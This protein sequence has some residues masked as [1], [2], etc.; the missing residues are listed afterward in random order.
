LGIVGAI[1]GGT[2]LGSLRIFC[3]FGL[4]LCGPI[5]GGIGGWI[6]SEIGKELH[7]CKTADSDEQAIKSCLLFLSHGILGGISG[8]GGAF[9]LLYLFLSDV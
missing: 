7:Q 2:I 3:G 1:V 5:L 9:G 6:G 8:F 4:I